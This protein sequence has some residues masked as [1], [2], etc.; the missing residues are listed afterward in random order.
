MIKNHFVA[1]VNQKLFAWHSSSITPR[2]N[3]APVLPECVSRA[4]VSYL[5]GRAG[6]GAPS[7]CWCRGSGRRRSPQAAA[8]AAAGGDTPSEGSS[9]RWL[10]PLLLPTATSPSSLTD[11]QLVQPAAIITLRIAAGKQNPDG[12]RRCCQTHEH[13][14]L[15]F[16]KS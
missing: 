7:G 12:N 3:S 1:A 14:H 8:A 13:H 16:S 15:V 2:W 10:R 5:S 4:G 11:L 9:S 6:G